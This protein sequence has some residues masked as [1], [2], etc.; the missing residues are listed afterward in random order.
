MS[1]LDV[2]HLL[3]EMGF[4]CEEMIDNLMMKERVKHGI[5]MGMMKHPAGRTH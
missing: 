5:T 4:G 1:E 3:M 2:V